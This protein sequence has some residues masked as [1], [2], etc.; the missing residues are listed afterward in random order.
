VQAEKTSLPASS[1]H[2]LSTLE[3]QLTASGADGASTTLPPSQSGKAM[4]VGG[5]EPVDV[6]LPVD[7]KVGRQFLVSQTRKEPDGTLTAET[8]T[9]DPFTM[10]IANSRREGGVQVS[11]NN[12]RVDAT[13]ITIDHIDGV[14]GPITAYSERTSD[15]KNPNK[16]LSQTLL[17]DTNGDLWATVNGQHGRLQMKMGD[18]GY[19]TGKFDALREEN[20]QGNRK[21]AVTRLSNSDGQKLYER[22]MAGE[23]F[24]SQY[25]N[26][27]EH[28]S[29]TTLDT[30]GLIRDS[31]EVM[32]GQVTPGDDK[33][34]RGIAYGIETGR[35]TVD[36]AQR[37]LTLRYSIQ[38]A[39]NAKM[40]NASGGSGVGNAEPHLD[41]LEDDL[42]K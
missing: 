35:L 16:P 31:Y 32:G 19:W 21:F 2:Q 34:F 23:N 20:V 18:N 7:G 40:G 33:Y 36:A 9:R 3:T 37:L 15:P 8:Q 4:S 29:G 12:R 27:E 25:N 13:P 42:S 14:D 38:R 17:K 24:V 10:A 1:I 6:F 22:G 41:D 28:L 30:M 5:D 26:R 11:V 39:K